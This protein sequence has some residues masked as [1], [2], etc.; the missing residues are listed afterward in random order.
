MYS[1]GGSEHI[2]AK[3]ESDKHVDK[4]DKTLSGD[5]SSILD[6]DHKKAVVVTKENTVLPDDDKMVSRS[7][8]YGIEV[9]LNVDHVK[10]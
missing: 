3:D 9:D 4:P 7:T 8:G 1:T 10:T 2:D 6:D 5:L